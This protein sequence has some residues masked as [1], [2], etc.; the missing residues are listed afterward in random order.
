MLEIAVITVLSQNIIVTRLEQYASTP[1]P[2]SIATEISLRIQLSAKH[3]R[4][5][6]TKPRDAIPH[7]VFCPT[8]DTWQGLSISALVL[9]QRRHRR[10]RSVGAEDFRSA[11]V[12]HRGYFAQL[13][14]KL[15]RGR[16][17]HFCTDQSSG[18]RLAMGN[19]CT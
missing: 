1:Q 16:E 2:L 4:T 6:T 13:G 10:G 9:H 7:G 17:F 12:V 11:V 15:R 8:E 5:G 14:T 18:I 19:G 3:R